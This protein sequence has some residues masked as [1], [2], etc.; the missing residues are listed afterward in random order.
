[1][2][3]LMRLISREVLVVPYSVQAPFTPVDL[4]DVAEVAAIV[5]T[6]PGHEYAAYELAGSE[7]LDTAAMAEGLGRIARG[8]GLQEWQ[9]DMTAAGTP[10]QVVKGLAKMMAYYDEHGLVGNSRV[11]SMLLGREPTRFAEAVARDLS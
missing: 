6:E 10:P 4:N 1:M 9:D 5:L 7:R 2:Q 11:L 3:N 8:R